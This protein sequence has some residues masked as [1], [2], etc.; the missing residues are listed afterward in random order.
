MPALRKPKVPISVAWY[1]QQWLQL[2]STT[3]VQTIDN[4]SSF[5]RGRR[6]GWGLDVWVLV[7][8]LKIALRWPLALKCHGNIHSKI[9]K[10]SSDDTT[11]KYKLPPSMR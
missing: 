3:V 7:N 10:R 11:Y 2:V 5:F 6:C 1:S 8:N 9:L 4:F